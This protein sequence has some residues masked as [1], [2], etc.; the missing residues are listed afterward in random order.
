MALLDFSFEN[1][2]VQKWVTVYSPKKSLLAFK[3]WGPIKMFHT[4]LFEILSRFCFEDPLKTPP[5]YS[6]SPLSIISVSYFGEL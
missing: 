2:F 6:P 5:L 4:G 3:F 1:G